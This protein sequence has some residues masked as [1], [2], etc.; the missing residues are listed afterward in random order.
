MQGWRGEGQMW[1][2]GGL[3]GPMVVLRTRHFTL[4]TQFPLLLRVLLRPV[5]SAGSSVEG[6]R[7][8]Q[9]WDGVGGEASD[10]WSIKW[11]R[12]SGQDLWALCGPTLDGLK[13]RGGQGTR[14]PRDLAP[15]TDGGESMMDGH[16]DSNTRR[17]GGLMKRLVPQGS[18][19]VRIRRRHW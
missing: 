9:K 2:Q 5:L 8:R 4:E 1:N 10:T 19:F 11:G 12:R 7:G 14:S 18:P 16:L 13:E 3:I 17:F 15:E 6:K